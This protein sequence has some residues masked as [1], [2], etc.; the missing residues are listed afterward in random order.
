MKRSIW[1]LH[2]VYVKK[3]QYGTAMANSEAKKTCGEKALR[4]SW[5]SHASTEKN[6]NFGN[7]SDAVAIIR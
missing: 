1:S 5:M 4:Y 6:M 2:T 3:N 7:T